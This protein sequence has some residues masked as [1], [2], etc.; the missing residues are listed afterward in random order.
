MKIVY[1]GT[2]GGLAE[3]LV[4]RMWQEGN[5]VYLLSDKELS[6]KPKQG[7]LHHFYRTPRK[8]ESFGKLLCSISPDC[9]IFAGKYYISSTHEEESD[10]D[11][12]CWLSHCGRLPR[13]RM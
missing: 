13:F 6:Q 8:G 11:V 4:E 2:N 10:A 1:I 5:D 12:T 3:T 7:S 9:V